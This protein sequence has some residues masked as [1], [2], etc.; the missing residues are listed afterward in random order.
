MLHIITGGSGSGK[1]EYA[2]NFA[3]SLFDDNEYENKIYA[4][5]MFPYEDEE[6]KRRIIKHR[7]QR[8]GKGFDTIE[9][10]LNIE[11]LKVQPKTVILLECMSNLLANEMFAEG[12]RVKE[13]KAV[14]KN[15]SEN[16]NRYIILPI[17]KMSKT[18]DVIVVTN[19]IFGDGNTYDEMTEDYVRGLGYINKELSKQAD[20]V[21]EVFC[22]IPIKIKGEEIC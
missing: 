18:A 11:Q 3:Q 22:G 20:S 15:F 17:I 10:P 21:T 5:T 16:L 7:K 8:E 1:S 2:E 4:A 14:V 13:D 9:Q 6:T 12:G 19:E